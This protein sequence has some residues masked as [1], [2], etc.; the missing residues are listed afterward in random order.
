MSVRR[1][2]WV[3]ETE[4]A[5]LSLGIHALLNK[6]FKEYARKQKEGPNY[7]LNME[8]FDNMV[9]SFTLYLS[10]AERLNRFSDCGFYDDAVEEQNAE[11][12]TNMYEDDEKNA[13]SNQP[14]AIVIRRVLLNGTEE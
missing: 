7:D 11:D 9:V 3:S 5:I 14:I 2:F 10:L 1:K 8:D 12:E 4:E 13:L 6:D